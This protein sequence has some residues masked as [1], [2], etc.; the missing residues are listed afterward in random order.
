MEASIFLLYMEASISKK[1]HIKMDVKYEL[2]FLFHFLTIRLKK[3]KG[4]A[5]VEQ[6]RLPALLPV[7]HGTRRLQEG[8]VFN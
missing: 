3:E 1:Q 4:T 8:Q 6:S 5:Q 7:V 2:C